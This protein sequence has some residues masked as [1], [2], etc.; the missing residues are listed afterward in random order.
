MT[1][2]IAKQESGI[3]T[4]T[5]PAAIAAAETAKA[6]I[7]SAY[8]VALN[9]PRSQEG[10]RTKI[11][12]ACKRPSFAA[13]AEYSKPV[14]GKKIIGPS[15]RFAET[16][17][18]EWGNVL[19][20]IQVV[21]EDE[22]VRRTKIMVID[23]ETN[24][25]YS[26]EIQVTKTVERKEKNLYGRIPISSRLNTNNERTCIVRATDDE[27]HNKEASLIS[28]A[29]RTEG[30]RII[31]ADIVED[32]L[33]EAR[34][35]LRN[36][37]AKDP[38][39]AQRKVFDSFSAIGVKPSDI[40]EYLGHSC[41]QIVPA[42]LQDLRGMYSAI[43]EGDATWQQYV[44]PKKKPAGNKKGLGEMAD[45]AFKV[46]CPNGFDP[47]SKDDCDKCDKRKDCPALD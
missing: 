1:T 34:L 45:D 32:A 11:I 47:K 42:E 19:T 10:A 6:R 25:A 9:N 12:E 17:L 22:N 29:V 30:L 20:D 33:D 14:G 36:R 21:H 35:T 24:T 18:R 5:D 39:A 31:P 7:Q 15:I 8:M 44:K 16:A 46:D 23:L 2:E 26:K 4:T 3:S 40:E 38:K 41:D 27:M 43:A 13:K 37:D 28:K